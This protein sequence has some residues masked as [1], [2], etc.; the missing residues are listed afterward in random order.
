MTYNFQT[1]PFETTATDTIGGVH[2]ISLYPHDN[3]GITM[4]VS[5]IVSDSTL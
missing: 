2:L 5:T 3:S 1:T 4:S